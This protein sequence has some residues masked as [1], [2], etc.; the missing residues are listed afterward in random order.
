MTNRIY[1]IIKTIKINAKKN[2]I[3]KEKSKIF[4]LLKIFFW[5]FISRGFNNIQHK[6]PNNNIKYLC[7]VVLNLILLTV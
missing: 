7:K 1:K 4:K 3:G 5:I 2:K 6:F